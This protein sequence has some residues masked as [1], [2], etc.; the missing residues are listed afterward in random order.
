M[1]GNSGLC[2]SSWVVS[3]YSTTRADGNQTANVRKVG[4]GTN[5]TNAGVSS[6]TTVSNVVASE[7]TPAR[8]QR[9]SLVG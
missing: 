8:S 9:H 3:D 6:D 1:E 2:V 5:Y 4:D 7:I